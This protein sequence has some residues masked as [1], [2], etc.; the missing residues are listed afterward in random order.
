MTRAR[1]WGATRAMP[2]ERSAYFLLV[3]GI[4][5]GLALSILIAA[6]AALLELPG[7]GQGR[8]I[9]PTDLPVTIVAVTIAY[10]LIAA[11]IRVGRGSGGP[12]RAR[13]RP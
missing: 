5:L 2:A 7:A 6:L 3:L 11:E 12:I 10:V 8:T 13:H 1:R 9:D 4:R